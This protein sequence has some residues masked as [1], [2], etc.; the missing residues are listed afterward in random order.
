MSEQV[1]IMSLMDS[2]ALLQML[3]HPQQEAKTATP[4]NTVDV[5]I[6]VDDNIE[7]GCRIFTVDKEAPIII[8]FHGNAEIVTDYDDVGPMYQQQNI[9]YAVA[10]YRGYG[11]STGSPLVSTFL[12]D[13]N[14]V[15]IQLRKWFRDNDYTGEIFVMGRSLGSAC[16]I[17]VGV[18]N[19]ED[20]DGMI[21]DSGFAMTL[22]LAKVLGLDIEPFGITEEQTFNNGGK[23]ENFKKPTFMLHGQLDQL[24]PV[25]QAEKLHNLCGA[26][27]RELQMIPGADHNSLIAI[28]GLM[29]F[30]AIKKFIDKTIGAI[31]DWRERRKAHKVAQE[32]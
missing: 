15:F 4:E 31:P 32:K 3:F 25:W 17:D 19:E 23:I 11:W 21:I 1:D 6:T 29:Y 30:Q 28:G 12:S 27:A 14:T 10:D 18:N 8:F 20:L 9:N 13:A 5:D 26:K 7:I 22:P 2:P 16:A 24:I